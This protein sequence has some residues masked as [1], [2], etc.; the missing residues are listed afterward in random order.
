[1]RSNRRYNVGAERPRRGQPLAVGVARDE[2]EAYYVA[3]NIKQRNRRDSIERKKRE[4]V[5]KITL[6]TLRFMQ[7]SGPD[8]N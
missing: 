3:I 4:A 1:M 6:P 2:E 5:S 8:D 7:G